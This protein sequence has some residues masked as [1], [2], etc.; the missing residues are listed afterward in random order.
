[1]DMLEL[2]FQI[3]FSKSS[4]PGELGSRSRIVI[5]FVR[6]SYFLD[7]AVTS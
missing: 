4:T 3:G 7:V 5:F 1:V 6:G 2:V